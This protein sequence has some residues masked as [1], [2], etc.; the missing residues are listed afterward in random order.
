MST[1]AHTHDLFGF[2][3]TQ[4]TQSITR[5]ASGVLSPAIW[6]GFRMAGR[7][8]CIAGSEVG[9]AALQRACEY[10][11]A[12]GDLL[13][14]SGAFVYRDDPSAMPW[15]HVMKVYQTIATAA[16][17]PVTFIL[18]DVVGSQ[19]GSLAVLD[20]WGRAMQTAIG[21]QH[22][23][24]LPVQ[25]GEMPVAE[26]IAACAPHLD[27]QVD[28][29]AI[30]SNAAAFPIAQLATLAGV[31][32]N[33]PQRVHFLGISR[34]SKGLQARALRLREIWPTAILSCDACEHRAQVGRGRPITADRTAVL[35]DLWDE[36]LDA[37]DQTE[38][39]DTETEAALRTMFPEA[40]DETLADLMT[41]SIG[42]HIEL[43][44]LRERTLKVIGPLATTASI[45][46][47]ANSEFADA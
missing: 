31:A 3:S 23:L 46:A 17:V 44:S 29:L 41:S 26:F 22:T 1:S 10:V 36:A 4:L 12:G 47:Y 34:N 45:Y 9:D 40:D 43:Q 25:A 7:S 28:G 35:A 14:D 42:A 8:L 27:R 33:V 32:A 24:L 37:W 6:E 38:V 13:V 21:E 16:T 19:T 18:P 39:D 20:R 30:P 2:E 15:A 5:Y 11:Q